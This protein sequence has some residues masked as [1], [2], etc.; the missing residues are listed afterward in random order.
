MKGFDLKLAMGK[1]V[2]IKGE[3]GSGKTRLL[4]G[5][6][7]EA[8]DLDLD[9]SLID[10]APPR[11]SAGKREAGGTAQ[12]SGKGLR[13]HRPA[14]ISA[15]RLQSKSKAE[16]MRMAGENA[17]ATSEALDEYLRR[18]TPLLFI[19]DLTIHL[20]EGDP[21]LLSEAIDSAETFVGTAY[22]GRSI[23]DRHRSGISKR[24]RE[25]LRAI[26]ARMDIV[27]AL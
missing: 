25:S 10:M 12:V 1:R 15:P 21:D 6:V 22:E 3:S 27:I 17:K 13:V 11:L 4:E 8:L 7:R 5:L 16:A 24:E 23:A 19:N 20:H 14:H 18:P 26:E 9:V 2:L